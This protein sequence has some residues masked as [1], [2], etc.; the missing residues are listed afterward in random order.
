MKKLFSIFIVFGMI[1]II[2]GAGG[3][4]S[5]SASFGESFIIMLLGAFLMGIG[6][7]GK[8]KYRKVRRRHALI[9]NKRRGIGAYSEKAC[10]ELA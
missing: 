9:R 4:E 8:E 5:F 1:L 3:Y 7:L 10:Q 2:T 6:V